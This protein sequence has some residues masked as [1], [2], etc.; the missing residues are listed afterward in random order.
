MILYGVTA[1]KGNSGVIAMVLSSTGAS[2]INLRAFNRL[3]Q[4]LIRGGILYDQ[5]RLPIDGQ[6]LRPPTQLEPP[7]MGRRIAVKI[8][9][10]CDVLDPDLGQHLLS[11]PYLPYPAVS[12]LL[13]SRWRLCKFGKIAELWLGSNRQRVALT[14]RQEPPSA[15][16]ASF[17]L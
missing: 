5:H 1:R 17:R 16:L 3:E 9:K 2:S 11:I 6:D 15:D 7:A 13:I 14:S 8:R 12:K 10:R 4:L